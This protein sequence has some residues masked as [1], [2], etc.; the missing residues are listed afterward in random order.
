MDTNL[1]E[2]RCVPCEG[3]TPPLE[4]FKVKDLMKEV[5]LWSLKNGRL[6]RQ[7]KFRNFL[8]AMKFVNT[9]AKLAE[10][11]S[12]HPD[13]LIHYNRVDLDLWTH[14]VKGLSENDFI[15]AAKIDRFSDKI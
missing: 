10:E 12:H 11:E 4:E 1:S 8:E 7:F 2:K 13:I 14:A 9:V 6:F 3:G 5:P 15:L